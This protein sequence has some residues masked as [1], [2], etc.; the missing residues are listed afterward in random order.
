MTTNEISRRQLAK[1]GLRT[2]AAASVIS[3]PGLDLVFRAHA[4]EP[5]ADESPDIF[6]LSLARSLSK[7]YSFLN[8]MMDAYAQGAIVRLS[9]SYT[10]QQGLKSTAFVYDNSVAI[11]AYLLRGRSEDM[12]R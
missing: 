3:L 12:A 7:A 6:A 9:Q 4:Q 11:N 1:I 10:D 2:A 8:A 5:L